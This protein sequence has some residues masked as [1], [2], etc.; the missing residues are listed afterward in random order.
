[1]S[2]TSQNSWPPAYRNSLGLASQRGIRTIAFPS[3]STG[4]YGYP[5]TERRASLSQPPWNISEPI[6]RSGAV[7]FVLFGQATL[8]TYEAV[9][10]TIF[11]R[12]SS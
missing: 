1:V 6:R 7:R 12:P 11:F 2:N 8:R 10:W 9:P 5:L 3:L 4:A